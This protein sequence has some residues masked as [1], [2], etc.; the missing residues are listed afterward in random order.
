[1]KSM[2][3]WAVVAG[4]MIAGL[5][6]S[7]QAQT[8]PTRAVRI[9][10]STPAGG[11]Q[12]AIARLIAQ[13]LSEK[14]GKPF[15]VENRPGAN[16]I[17]AAQTAADAP[18]DGY[19]L[20]MATDSTLSINPHLYS[21]LPYDA[22]DFVAITQMVA[23]PSH[24]F[25]N[26]QLPV[27]SFKEFIAYAK[28]RPGELNYGS[29]G[30]GSNPHLAAE[31]IKRATGIDMVHIPFKGSADSMAAFAANQVQMM[32]SS[33]ASTLALVHAGKIKPLAVSGK[34]RIAQLPDA[35]TFAEAE[36][37]DI[38]FGSWF[39]LVAK[40]GTPE[41]IINLLSRHIVAYVG[42]AQF[43]EKIA[44]R[45]AWEVVASPA[46]TFT[47]FLKENRAAYGRLIKD[48]QIARIQ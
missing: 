21:K 11:P 48:A 43:R 8:Y 35:P 16:T 46:A 45:Y 39:G 2:S 37:P 7:A 12:D 27:K 19:T 17:I 42:S 1:M 15:I 29:Y 30:H 32:V 34:H 20:M 18:A 14:L 31:Q 33:V 23:S 38:Y 26:S 24:L 5:V 22:E 25:V 6:S 44:P 41:A 4:I 47:A 28:A 36:F 10:S 13:E 3:R 9:I 40:K